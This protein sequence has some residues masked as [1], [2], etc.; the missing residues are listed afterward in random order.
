MTARSGRI[1]SRSS[2]LRLSWDL[3]AA[4]PCSLFSDERKRRIQLAKNEPSED[5]AAGV[6]V[7]A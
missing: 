6:G 4:G 3:R 1:D 2:W 7:V 5:G